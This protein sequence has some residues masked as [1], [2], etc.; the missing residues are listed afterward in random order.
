ML[1]MIM[2]MHQTVAGGSRSE[3]SMESV[4]SDTDKNVNTTRPAHKKKQKSFVIKWNEK[5]LKDYDWLKYEHG[6]MFS[7]LC[8]NQNKANTMSEGRV[9]RSS[10][11]TR[12]AKSSSIKEAVCEIALRKSAMSS[13]SNAL[14]KKDE[15]ISKCF[16]NLYLTAKE[17][18]PLPKYPS[19]YKLITIKGVNLDA[20][21]VQGDNHSSR[22]SGDEILDYI[23]HVISKDL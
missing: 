23:V 9:I 17:N 18:I 4:D 20:L 2:I 10:T 21:N 14:T 15:A 19:L 12:H 8:I 11:L 16:R 6:K 13:T 3:V 7:F 22:I 1:M 5:W